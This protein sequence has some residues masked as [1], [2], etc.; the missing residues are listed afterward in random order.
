MHFELP[1]YLF[2]KVTLCC[3][4]L[5]FT[6]ELYIKL[7]GKLVVANLTFFQDKEDGNFNISNIMQ[8][9]SLRSLLPLVQKHKFKRFFAYISAN[10]GLLMTLDVTGILE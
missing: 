7:I 2:G 9:C 6:K 3:I 5:L 1:F 8:L 4:C 10:L